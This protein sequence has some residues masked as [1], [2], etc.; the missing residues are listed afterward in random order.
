MSDNNHEILN[1][2]RLLTPKHQTDLLALVQVAY[3]AEKSV[4]K[5]LGL[6][7]QTDG[8]SSL[9]SQEYSCENLLQRSEK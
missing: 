3:V 7:V 6:D 5:S 4:R 9:K 1:I 2:Y 8:V